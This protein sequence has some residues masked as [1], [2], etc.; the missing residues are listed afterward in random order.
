MSVASEEEEEEGEEGWG[1]EGAERSVRKEG[2]EEG[3]ARGE[4][5]AQISPRLYR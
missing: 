4:G 2:W 1:A 5:G 3:G